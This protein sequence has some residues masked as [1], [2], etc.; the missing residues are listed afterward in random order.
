MFRRPQRRSA[1]SVFRGIAVAGSLAASA[2]PGRAQDPMTRMSVDTLGVQALRES[3]APA[4]SA[5][6]RHVAFASLASNLVAGDTNGN[7]DVF[8]HDRLTRV[9]VRVSVSSA[10]K[11]AQGPSSAPSISA[12]GRFVAFTSTARNLVS[13]DLNNVSDVFVHDRDPDG[14]G[15]FDESNATTERVSVDSSG[16]EGNSW[17]QEAAISGDGKLV[18]FSS[19]ASN[20]V[21]GDT[22]GEEDVFVHDRTAGTTV[23]VSVDSA[24][25][26]G[27]DFSDLPAISADGSC[28]AFESWASNFDANDTDTTSDIFVHDL[29]SGSFALV[30]GD[31]NGYAD[32]FVFDRPAGAMSI[33]SLDSNGAQADGN[34]FLPT[35]SSDGQVVSFISTADN[36]VPDDTNLTWDVLRHDRTSGATTGIS[37]DCAGSTADGRS[38]EASISADGQVVAFSS[39]ADDLVD[40]DTNG[41]EDVFARDLGAAGPQA[42]W[43][44]YGAGWAGT[45]GI[46][47]FTA[48]AD[49]EF[50]A[51]LS[52][53]ITNSLH[54]W[55]VGFV[56]VGMDRASIPTRAGGTILV[57][58]ALIV[59]VPLAPI[60]YSLGVTIPADR[61]LCGASA[62]LQ[63]IE[64]DAGASGGLS[65]TPGL[66]LVF[67]H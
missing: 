25:V 49:P 44:S 63:V 38:P 41:Y 42:S 7:W 56:L 22:N 1:R 50:S 11:Q 58:W 6:G 62:D 45:Y 28:V 8:V 61:D 27:N 37:L 29:A 4:I 18:A 16:V 9:T 24:G 31:Q 33:A 23:R 64:L 3:A 13:G 47:T 57:D 66:E 54:F 2:A 35:L 53:D 14:N 32:V 21:A 52:L 46:P 51:T 43:S 17:S 30:P 59:T 26:E 48:S 5:N 60:G 20:L 10:G 67:G 12:D 55:T 65:F 39:F 36:L 19:F 34:S 15:V 40:N